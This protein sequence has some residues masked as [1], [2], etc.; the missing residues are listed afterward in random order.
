M[1][2]QETNKMFDAFIRAS[3]HF[4]M[5][6]FTNKVGYGKT[7]FEYANLAEIIDCIRL[8]LLE[9]GFFIA[10]EFYQNEGR[11]WIKTYLQYKDG[12]SIGNVIFPI[13]MQSKTTQEIGGQITYLKRYSLSSICSLFAD[14]DNDAKE[15]E[16]QALNEPNKE[17][18]TAEQVK[19][20]E[21]MLVVLTESDELSMLAWC[22]V[23]SIKEI[24]QHKFSAVKKALE[25]KL[26]K[27]GENNEQQS[28]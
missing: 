6:V 2:V 10:H 28:I 19:I 25:M 12:G 7:N 4:R 26:N 27:K 20:L 21:R 8:P 11:Q 13:T 23:K 3:K 16:G 9:E 5:P 17:P 15:V 24:P 14:S 22:Q 1:T 18:L